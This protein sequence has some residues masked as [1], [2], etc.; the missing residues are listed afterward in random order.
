MLCGSK[1]TKLA[2]WK[3]DRLSTYGLLNYLTQIEVSQ[4]L[5]VLMEKRLVEQID[6]D[7]H[8]PVVQLTDYGSDVMKSNV[9]LQGPLPLPGELL[10]K[11]RRSRTDDD[12]DGAVGPFDED[13]LPPPDPDLLEALRRW[14]RDAA[15]HLKAPVYTVLHTVS[16]ELIA[17]AKP[18]SRDELE[19]IKGIGPA[20]IEQ[21]GETILRLVEKHA[22]RGSGATSRASENGS[23]HS[24]ELLPM[25]ARPGF[26]WTWRVLQLGASIAECAA[27]RGMTTTEV[28]DDLAQA[29]KGGLPLE[30]SAVV[31]TEDGDVTP[32]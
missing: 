7:R 5:D 20:K 22:G 19:R 21:Y 23:P 2:R 27:I 32:P 8:R 25:N 24:L 11:L 29:R 17:R 10:A 3:L 15:D 30:N 9:P 28:L 14:R 13:H 12:E 31:Q 26:Y 4:L 18:A 1:S 16:L 6:V